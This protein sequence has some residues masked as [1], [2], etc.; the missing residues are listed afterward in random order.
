MLYLNVMEE[1]KMCS[2]GELSARG[3]VN[4]L[5]LEV[6]QDLAFLFREVENYEK[7]LEI[8]E[9]IKSIRAIKESE[10]LTKYKFEALYGLK[11]YSDA[12]V[13][14]KKYIKYSKT[15]DKKI[16]KMFQSIREKIYKPKKVFQPKE[17]N[18]KKQAYKKPQ[19]KLSQSTENYGFIPLNEMDEQKETE[20]YSK[21]PSQARWDEDNTFVSF[22][23]EIVH[24]CEMIQPTQS[25]LELVQK[26]FQYTKNLVFEVLGADPRV[27]IF[28]SH[29]TGMT[30]PSSDLDMTVL[31]VKNDS[32]KKMELA[33]REKWNLGEVTDLKIVSNA[34]IPIIKFVFASK[35]SCDVCFGQSNG[36]ETG[37][38]MKE[39]LKWYLPAKFIILVMKYFLAQ[40]KLNDTYQGGVGSF[41]LQ[42]MAISSVQTLWKMDKQRNVRREHN[43]GVYLLHF[44]KMYSFDLNYEFVGISVRNG[45][46]FFPKV[47]RKFYNYLRPELLCV[48]NPWEKSFDVGKNSFQ[49]KHI[50]HVFKISFH[51]LQ[52]I[53][54]V[55]NG[56]AGPLPKQ[57][58]LG[59]IVRMDETLRSRPLAIKSF[60][61]EEDYDEKEMKFQESVLGKRKEK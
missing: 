26:A 2:D 39:M 34:K 61:L 12:K 35:V 33:L 38:K 8:I 41:L 43:L 54:C 37:K 56:D 25:E 60:G 46:F 24:F 19:K 52:D 59:C 1:L 23:N 17:T 32:Y 47:E 18:G 29:L 51:L 9:E 30:V 13:V 40:R 58:I 57:T 4:A 55:N 53:L 27:E 16:L 10:D 44:L 48:E 6:L 49:I 5:K 14:G 20:F 11:K 7:T 21:W 28:G 50:K 31:D 36:L 42:L 15:K 3:K 45:G 22:H